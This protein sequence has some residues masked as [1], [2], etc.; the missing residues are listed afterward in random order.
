MQVW[1]RPIV[2]PR[3]FPVPSTTDK[4]KNIRSSPFSV[5]NS[6][7]FGAVAQWRVTLLCFS[8]THSSRTLSHLPFALCI[9]SSSFLCIIKTLEQIFIL[10]AIQLD[11]QFPRPL[12][13]YLCSNPPWF[14]PVSLTFARTSLSFSLSSLSLFLGS[15]RKLWEKEMKRET[16]L[17]TALA[18]FKSIVANEHNRNFASFYAT[19][20]ERTLE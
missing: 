14:P 8:F 13:K 3:G 20:T 17:S 5:Q 16:E 10:F 12:W 6:I 15:R 4:T 11:G 2:T 18:N 7:P 1:W 9:A 19:N